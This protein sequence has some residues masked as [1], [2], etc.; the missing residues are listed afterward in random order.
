MAEL[1]KDSAD[2]AAFRKLVLNRVDLN[3]FRGGRC[4][5]YLLCRQ[6]NLD[7]MIGEAKNHIR[8]ELD[9]V[10]FIRKARMHTNLLWGLSTPWQRSICRSQAKLLIQDK[11]ESEFNSFKLSAVRRLDEAAAWRSSDED[12][13]LDKKM[14]EDIRRQPC[15]QD[16]KFMKRYIALCTPEVLKFKESRRRAL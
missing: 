10:R 3:K 4:T 8:R 9:V 15:A 12:D 16:V 14:I 11:L 6:R 1:G 13:P 5:R 7:V 2:F